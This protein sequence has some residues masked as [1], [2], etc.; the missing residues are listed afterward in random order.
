MEIGRN[1]LTNVFNGIFRFFFFFNGY[2]AFVGPGRFFSFLLCSQSLRLLE[3]VISLSPGLY[4]NT[5]QH[6]HRK[7]IYT[8]NTHALSGIRTHDHS[9]LTGE[10][11][12]CLRP[13]GYRDR[14]FLGTSGVEP[15]DY[16]TRDTS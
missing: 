1:W 10:D 16:A 13:L 15:S 6:K 9:I 5:G 12:S 8:A 4:L 14:L 11:N 7:N 3:R 2:I